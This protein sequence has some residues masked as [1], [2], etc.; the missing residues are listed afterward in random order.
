MED[1]K[2]AQI[3]KMNQMKQLKNRG[4]SLSFISRMMHMSYG[5]AKRTL[6]KIQKYGIKQGLDSFDVSRVRPVRGT[7]LELTP[8]A[9]QRYVFVK[10]LD[11]NRVRMGEDEIQR[12][13]LRQVFADYRG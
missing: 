11:Q 13:L 5:E 6:E 10:R 8:E 1:P 2:M 4:M 9:E 12:N 3:A 7:C